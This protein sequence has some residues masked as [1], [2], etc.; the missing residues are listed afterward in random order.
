MTENEWSRN[1]APKAIAMLLHIKQAAL[2]DKDNPMW[3]NVCG[4]GCLAV[5]K[6]IDEFVNDYNRTLTACAY[7]AHLHN[8][9]ENSC[10]EWQKIG[11]D[12]NP[13]EYSKERQAELKAIAERWAKEDESEEEK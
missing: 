1:K 12:L 11:F 8:V 4:Y 5:A 13:S 3:L 6:I 10:R 7:E 9:Y 2:E